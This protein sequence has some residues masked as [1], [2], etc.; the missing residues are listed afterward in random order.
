MNPDITAELKN[1]SKKIAR[2]QIIGTPAA[3]LIG[4]G[5]YGLFV[6]SGDAFHP[7]LNDKNIVYAILMAGLVLEIW[8][9]YLLMPLLKELVKKMHDKNT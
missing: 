6:A 7:L 9:F 2:T 4:L 3:M 8:Q 1:I 5:L